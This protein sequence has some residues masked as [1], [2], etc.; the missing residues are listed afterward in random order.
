MSILATIMAV[1]FSVT[2]S[3]ISLSQTVLEVQSQSR[4][5][6]ALREY[7]HQVLTNLPPEA[8]VSLEENDAQ[9]ASVYIELPS[10]QFP[11]NGQQHIAKQ[12]WLSG[13][14]DRDGLVS[15]IVE[16]SN[17]LEDE[18]SPTTP[19]SFQAELLGKLANIRWDFYDPSR[20][21]WSPEWTPA[22]G[23][24]SQVK[25]YYS[26]PEYPEEHM[27]YFWIPNR[28]PPVQSSSQNAQNATPQE[29]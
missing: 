17:L 2:R 3:S 22:M 4:Q 6:S 26:F 23:R 7:L 27:L 20:D 9:L 1:I 24:P 21:E 8:R 13:S 25:F 16:M 19:A 11:A 14:K 28:T 29:P 18:V 10:T 5:Q 12:L 15:F